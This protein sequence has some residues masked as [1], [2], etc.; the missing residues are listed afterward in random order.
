[1][2]IVYKITGVDSYYIY[3]YMVNIYTYLSFRIVEE[4]KHLLKTK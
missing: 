4:N 1:M 3:V 2:Q